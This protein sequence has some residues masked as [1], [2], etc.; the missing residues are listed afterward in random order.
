[1][2]RLLFTTR[3]WREKGIFLTAICL[4]CFNAS[5]QAQTITPRWKGVDATTLDETST[6]YLFNVGLDKFV[7]HGSSWGTKAILKFPDYGTGFRVTYDTNGYL[8]KSELSNTSGQGGTG[9]YLSL[10]LT[11][12][13]TKSTS[14]DDLGYFLDRESPSKFTLNRVTGT[15]DDAYVYTLSQT[16]GST[17][18]MTANSDGT[19]IDHTTTPP[20]AE[21]GYWV[22]V[23]KQAIIDALKADNLADALGGL[24]VDATYLLADQNFS[25][26][27]E[28]FNSWA[29]TS[30]GETSSDY[31]YNWRNGGT[32]SDSWNKLVATKEWGSSASSTSENAMYSNVSIEGQGTFTHTAFQ[33]PATGW[34]AIQCQGFYAGYPASLYAT[35]VQNDQKNDNT[36]T[37]QDA[38]ADFAL[39]DTT[40]NGRT[41]QTRNA[42]QG[43]NA[44]KAFYNSKYSN[45]LYFFAQEGNSITIGISKPSATKGA[46]ADYTNGGTSYYHDL[47]YVAVDNFQLKFF[48]VDPIVFIDDNSDLTYLQRQNSYTKQEANA[49]T[50]LKRNMTKGVWNTLVLPINVSSAQ[51]KYAFGD[52]PNEVELAKLTGLNGNSIQFTTVDLSTDN[53]KALEAGHIYI[54]KPQLDPIGE[55]VT[56][57]RTDGNTVTVKGPFYSLGRHSYTDYSMG[58]TGVTENSTDYLMTAHGTYVNTECP[59]G[60]YVLSRG[61]M[62]HVKSQTKVKGFRCWFTT[63]DG[64]SSKLSISIDGITDPSLSTGLEDIL[65]EPGKQPTAD[66]YNTNGQLVRRN[67]TSHDGLPKGIYISNGK[68]FVV[69]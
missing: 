36:V 16:L 57:N 55:S 28:D 15:A 37:L 48:G 35:V 68:K 59:S 27:N 40:V 4:F 20:N 5:V 47:D 32:T 19:T 38:T 34:Y 67:A 54:I 66:I 49:S 7:T 2:L 13:G 25:R 58:T 52:T 65:L 56:V 69:K 62:Y 63:N 51:L 50:M 8:F 29:Q 21:N 22:L 42:T 1:M 26:N 18:Y 17:Y 60:S 43:L 9:H 11:G 53:P 14:S 41:I 46:T 3:L 45:Q 31:R 33:A 44:G 12:Y 24:N 23:P 6:V 30:T 61:D 10:V 39:K 64:S